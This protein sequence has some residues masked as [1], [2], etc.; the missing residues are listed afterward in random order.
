MRIALTLDQD[1][2]EDNDYL[3]ALLEAGVRRDEIVV[4]RPGDPIQGG[5]DGV[6]IAGGD[7]VDPAL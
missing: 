4:L 1:L 3:R 2:P 6:V 5:F 7:D